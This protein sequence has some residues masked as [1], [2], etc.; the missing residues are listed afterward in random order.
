MIQER[1]DKFKQTFDTFMAKSLVSLG[2]FNKDHNKI[3]DGDVVLILDKKK[4]A[5]PV[6]NSTR[7]WLGVVEEEISLRS[8]KVLYAQPSQHGEINIST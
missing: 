2:H 3:S 1:I 6:K 4:K 8:F 5:L 7:Y